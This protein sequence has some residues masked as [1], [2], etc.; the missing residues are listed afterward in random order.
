MQQKVAH[1]VDIKREEGYN[2]KHGRFSCMEFQIKDRGVV[3]VVLFEHVWSLPYL[4]L[5]S[6]SLADCLTM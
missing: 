6:I 1:M 5:W 4:T 3:V 2:E